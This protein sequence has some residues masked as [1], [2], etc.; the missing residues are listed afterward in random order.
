MK[1]PN[2]LNIANYVIDYCCSMG[3]PVNKNKIKILL[4]YISARYFQ[5]YGCRLFPEPFVKGIYGPII[6]KVQGHLSVVGYSVPLTLLIEFLEGPVENLAKPF[7]WADVKARLKELKRN[8]RFTEVADPV[9]NDLAAVPYFD[10][11][12]LVQAESALKESM[13]LI[14]AGERLEYSDEELKAA[15]Y[16]TTV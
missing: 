9:L 14:L 12:K 6:E 16:R 8:R 3:H 10:I 2:C 15:D 4:Y 11:V 1:K 5:R 7:P 13:K